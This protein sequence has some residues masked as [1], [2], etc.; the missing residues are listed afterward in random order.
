MVGENTTSGL[1]LSGRYTS[2]GNVVISRTR[3]VLAAPDSQP[4]PLEPD[5]IGPRPHD[6]FHDVDHA[7]REVDVDVFVV[8]AGPID[9]RRAACRPPG[10][11]RGPRR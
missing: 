5:G 3:A 2:A 4:L 7:G 8:T 6:R 10:S 9:A 1:R 11:T